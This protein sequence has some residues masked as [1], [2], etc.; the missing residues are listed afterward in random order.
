[1]RGSADAQVLLT[2]AAAGGAITIGGSGSGLVLTAATLAALQGFGGLQL[3]DGSG[4]LVIDAATLSALALPQFGAQASRI[5]IAGQG[6]VQATTVL[7]SRGAITMAAGALLAT[8]DHDLTLRAGGDLQIARLDA[9]SGGVVLV[10]GGRILDAD[11]DSATNVRAAWLVMRGLGPVLAAGQSAHPAAIDV[12][13]ARVDID[14]PGG[15][16]LRDTAADGRT[17]Y[18][19]L[20]GGVLYQQIE[21]QGPSTR[22]AS[23]GTPADAGV[24]AAWLNALRPLSELRDTETRARSALGVVAQFA[25]LPEQSAAALYLASLT[26]DPVLPDPA[27]AVHT[28]LSAEAWGLALRLEQGWVLGSASRQPAATGLGGLGTD[29]FDYWEDSLVL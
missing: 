2:P 3:G 29:G 14:I 18:N 25:D 21:A 24:A 16:V 17:R 12:E 27:L 11:N 6:A 26:A 4:P 1:V 28:G 23:G 8:G 5:E 15:L 13:A 10:S 22:A 19:L 20:L 7:V 9:G